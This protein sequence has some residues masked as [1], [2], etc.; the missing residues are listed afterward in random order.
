AAAIQTDDC[1]RAFIFSFG[2]KAL[3]RPIET[4]DSDALFAFFLD[5]KQ[6]GFASGIE[7]V[8]AALL[9]HPMFIYRVETGAPGSVVGQPGLRQL[10][11]HEL[12]QRLSYNLWGTLPDDELVAAAANSELSTPEGLRSHAERMLQDDRAAPMFA[13]F[14]GQWLFLDHLGSVPKDATLHPTYTA[15]IPGLLKQELQLFLQDQVQNGGDLNSLFTANFGFL[16]ERLAAFYGVPGV[17]GEAFV[18]T[19]MP[20]E[21]QRFGLMTFAGLLSVEGTVQGVSLSGSARTYPIGRGRFIRERLACETVPPPIPNATEEAGA[22]EAIDALNQQ[23]GG[24]EHVPPRVFFEKVTSTNPV[25]ANCH[26][27]LEP[28]GFALETFG[29]DGLARANDIDGSP[30]LQAGNYASLGNQ[31]TDLV[32]AISGPAELGQKLAQSETVKACLADN[33]AQYTL[34]RRLKSEDFE[35]LTGAAAPSAPGATQ[36]KELYL[37][38]VTSDLYRVRKFD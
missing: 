5:G 34:G 28:L 38:L 20:P 12:A 18:K 1:A 33:L 8:V 31:S 6:E 21:A 25:C 2:S 32:G 26:G 19:P 13:D 9:Q 10:T 16:N 29:A 15:E 7:M 22:K 23:Y 36:L 4:A 3:R 30:A 17:T 27:F 24:G 14:I 11:G 35:C 37:G